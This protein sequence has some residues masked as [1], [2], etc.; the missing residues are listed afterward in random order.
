LRNEK[1]DFVV[2]M[3]DYLKDILKRC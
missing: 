2:A 3:T 1:G